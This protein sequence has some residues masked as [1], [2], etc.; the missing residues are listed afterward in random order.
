MSDVQTLIDLAKVNAPA[1]AVLVLYLLF[2][3]F[4]VSVKRKKGENYIEV[5]ISFNRDNQDK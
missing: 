5:N 4:S 3:R 1:F 2:K